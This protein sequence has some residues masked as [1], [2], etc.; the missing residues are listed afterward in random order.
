MY[1][2]LQLS[3]IPFCICN[4]VLY[5]FICQWTS[6]LLPCPSYCKWCC[7]EGW[8][9]C[10]FLSCGFLRVYAPWWDRWV[11]WY[12]LRTVLLG[13]SS[14]QFGFSPAHFWP[15]FVYCSLSPSWFL[16]Q[17]DNSQ[18]PYTNAYV[19]THTHVHTPCSLWMGEGLS[20]R[21]ICCCGTCRSLCF[22]VWWWSWSRSEGTPS[23]WWR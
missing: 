2:S 12:P 19:C 10:V 5:P 8:G 21:L 18:Y 16:P 23:L 4:T 9:T 6:R 17:R 20:L 11:K 22:S 3:N 1:S 7:S 15:I 14:G 13:E